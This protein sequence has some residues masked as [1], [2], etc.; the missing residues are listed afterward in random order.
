MDETTLQILRFSQ[1]GY[2]C[3]QIVILLALTPMG[4][5]NPMLVR[6]MAG[7]AYGCG[8]G[9]GS[10]GVLTG[11]CCLISLFAAKGRDDETASDRLPVMIAEFSDWFLHSFGAKNGEMTCEAIVGEQGIAAAQQRCGLMVSQV[12]PK[13]LEILLSNG[14]D[15]AA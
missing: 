7:L 4:T 10:C 8:E 12:Y 13:V 14:F 9:K 11:G 3:A 1:K 15:P 6:A 2:S 5:E